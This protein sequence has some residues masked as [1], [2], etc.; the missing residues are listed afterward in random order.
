MIELGY[1]TAVKVEYV[2]V[3]M[4]PNWVGVQ[5]GLH[6]IILCNPKNNAVKQ[7]LYVVVQDIVGYYIWY[8]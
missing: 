8:R 4:C 7:V 1:C 6:L 2:G 5:S 3:S